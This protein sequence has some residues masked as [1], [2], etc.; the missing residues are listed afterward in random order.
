MARE[1]VRSDLHFASCEPPDPTF[2]R[3]QHRGVLPPPPSAAGLRNAQ[4]SDHAMTGTHQA[5]EHRVIR[6]VL[7]RARVDHAYGADAAALVRYG[8]AAELLAP[9]AGDERTLTLA[10][11]ALVRTLTVRA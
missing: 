11:R 4:S 10:S 2:E 7:A 1:V 5:H 6:V 3:P 9:P 8:Y